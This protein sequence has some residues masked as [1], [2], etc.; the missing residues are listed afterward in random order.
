MKTIKKWSFPTVLVFGQM[1]LVRAN[2]LNY[3]FGAGE[4][5]NDTI[6]SSAV[7]AVRLVTVGQDGSISNLLWTIH[8]TDKEW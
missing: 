8:G 5:I 4:T 6:N 7:T 3:Q 1:A 2:G